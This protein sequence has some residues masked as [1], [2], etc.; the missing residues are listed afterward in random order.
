MKRLLPIQ[1]IIFLIIILPYCTNQ[2]LKDQKIDIHRISDMLKKEQKKDAKGPIKKAKKEEGVYLKK[3]VDEGK[4]EERHILPTH[5]IT[6]KFYQVDAPIIIRSLARAAN[7]NVLISDKVKGKLTINIDNTPWDQAFNAVLKTLGLKY[8]WVGNIIRVMTLEEMEHDLKIRQIDTKKREQ[9]LIEER[10]GPLITE[11]IPVKFADPKKLKDN[12][13][14]LLTKD[15]QGKPRGSIIYDEYTNSLVIEAIRADMEKIIPM[16]KKLDRPTP[17]ILIE[18]NIV[19]ANRETAKELGVQWGGLYHNVGGDINYW[20][21]P[22][23]STG[24]ISDR[25]LGEALDPTTGIAAN[26]P[27]SKDISNPSES[28]FT[29]GYLSQRMGRYILNFQLQ[30]LQREGKLNILS[31]PSITTLDNHMALIESGAEV[32]FQTVS[33]EGNIE[34]EWKKAVLK[35]EVTPHVIDKEYIKL[36]IVTYKDELDFSNPV[37]NN[38]TII[39]KKAETN[40]ILKD[41][42]TAVIGGLSKETRTH[43]ESGIPG[44]KDLPLLGSIFKSI[45]KSK[46]MEDILI[47]IT[48]HIIER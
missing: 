19:E 46:T 41:G 25:P 45:G 35:L 23:A 4:R 12:L 21:T 29:I 7:I 32:P 40:I 27:I 43:S 38:P 11:I 24:N 36:K 10:T 3:G 26:F 34:I 13:T 9:M 5:P 14:N 33:A 6:L 44:L 31:S 2:N 37:N 42:Q 30:A 16:I 39:T 28:W 18:A 17:Q 20:I 22:G 8:T 47:F 15:K 1:F 48:P